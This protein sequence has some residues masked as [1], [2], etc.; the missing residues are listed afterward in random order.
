MPGLVDRQRK[1]PQC[2]ALLRGRMQNLAR[3]WLAPDKGGMSPTDQRP[4]RRTSADQAALARVGANVRARL[5]A[6]PAIYPVT[7]DRAEIFALGDFLSPAECA[8][9]IALIDMTAEPSKLFEPDYANAH[10]TSYSGDVDPYDPFV[11]K[12]QRRI[13]DLLGLPTEFGETIQGQRYLPGQ[14]FK[15]HFDWF[16]EDMGYWPNEKRRGGQRSYTAMVFL[17]DVEAGGT[18][19]FPS[20]GMSITPK[21]G[22]LLAWNN[23][24]ADGTL[25]EWTLHAGMPVIAG[26][27]YI[28]TKWYRTRRW[29]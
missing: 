7:Q 23:A 24:A 12:I 29:G 28:I 17:N 9:M 6:N 15:S 16:F 21:A 26:H 1:A 20:L 8:K 18:T 10:R 19:D 4:F 2:G 25:N 14:E 11:I 22:V 3:H 13:D 27:K 5:A